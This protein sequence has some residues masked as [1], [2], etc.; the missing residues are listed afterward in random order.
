MAN[1]NLFS[2]FAHDQ[3][4]TFQDINANGDYSGAPRFFILEPE[5]DEIFRVN[6]LAVHVQDSGSLDTGSYGNGIVLTNGIEVKA[7]KRG[8]EIDL[9]EQKKIFT[10]L[11]WRSYCREE[12]IST[13]GTGDNMAMWVMDF[14]EA[15]DAPFILD[16]SQ[17]EKIII[18]LNDDFSGLHGHF[19]R[20]GLRVDKIVK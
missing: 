18:A 15:M 8:G 5:P 4:G 10:N 11:D 16:G 3:D 17:G 7:E 1:T 9:T 12:T 2:R 6:Y 13:Y 20:F 19:F 14:D